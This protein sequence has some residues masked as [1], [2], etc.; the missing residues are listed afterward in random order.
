M[1]DGLKVVCVGGGLDEMETKSHRHGTAQTHE[2]GHVISLSE[3]L[4]PLSLARSLFKILRLPKTTG[5]EAR[6]AFMRF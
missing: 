2:G 6:I 5:A 3:Y 1:L 4:A